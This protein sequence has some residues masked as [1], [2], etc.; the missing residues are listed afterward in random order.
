MGWVG[1]SAVPAGSRD[2]PGDAALGTTSPP[3]AG[4][5]RRMSLGSVPTTHRGA[6]GR[7]QRPGGQPRSISR[8]FLPK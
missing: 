6:R 4:V 1:G 3:H 2:P 5:T 8:R 7:A